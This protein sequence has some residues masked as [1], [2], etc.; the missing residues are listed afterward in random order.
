VGLDAENFI[1]LD[2]SKPWVFTHRLESDAWLTPEDAAVGDV[3]RCCYKGTTL[4]WWDWGAL[5]DHADTVVTLP[6]WI[7]G[8]VVEPKDNGGWPK[9]VVPASN[10]VEFSLAE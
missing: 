4:D 6:C 10:V 5:E 1:S 9:I 8:A 3:F 7:A 2:F